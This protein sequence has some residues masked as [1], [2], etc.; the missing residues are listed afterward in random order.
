M[1][2]SGIIWAIC[3][4]A[5]R[6]RQITTPAPHHSFFY[7]PGALPAAQPT[8]SKHWK[9][10]G[11]ISIKLFSERSRVTD[12]LRSSAKVTR[13]TSRAA[14]GARMSARDRQ[15][16]ADAPPPAHVAAVPLPQLTSHSL[17]SRHT[18]SQTGWSDVAESAATIRSPFSGYNMA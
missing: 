15:V 10:C 5:T 18:T 7:R 3:K 2:G 6:S 4:S 17:H 12:L 9:Q 11:L 14:A 8:A 13:W 16:P 1:S